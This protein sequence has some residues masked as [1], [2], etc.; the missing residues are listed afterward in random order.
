MAVVWPMWDWRWHWVGDKETR[1]QARKAW[2]FGVSG[3]KRQRQMEWIRTFW[4][5]LKEKR[6]K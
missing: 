6:I 5:L 2:C 3:A 4:R 1:P